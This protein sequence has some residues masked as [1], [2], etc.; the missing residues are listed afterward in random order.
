MNGRAIL[1]AIFSA[2]VA[3]SVLASSSSSSS[4]RAGRAVGGANG[5]GWRHPSDACL[6]PVRVEDARGRG[7]RLS[8][9]QRRLEQ[10]PD[11]QRCA[12]RWLLPFP[13][14]AGTREHRRDGHVQG[15]CW[16]HDGVGTGRARGLPQARRRARELPRH[17]VRRR[18]GVLRDDCRRR[19]ETRR[20]EFLVGGDQVHDRGQGVADHEGAV[21][22]RDR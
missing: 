7:A 11:E 6:H 14:R 5:A 18:S 19:E 1:V 15:R 16:L 10:A 9:V 22:F 2:A 4:R 21:G 13:V 17:A 12:R 20:A 3:A 8:A